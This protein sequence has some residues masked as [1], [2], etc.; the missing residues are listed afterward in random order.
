MW[1]LKYPTFTDLQ[2]YE[3]MMLNDLYERVVHCGNQTIKDA[4]IPR[5]HKKIL[6]TL[7][8]GKVWTAYTESEKLM[9]HIFTEY[10]RTELN[11]YFK[12]IHTKRSLRNATQDALIAKYQDMMGE[13]LDVLGYNEA[14]TNVKKA[15]DVTEMKGAKACTYCNRGYIFTISTGNRI[16]DKIARPELDH[17]Y[18]KSKYPLLSMNYFNLIPS[19]SVCNSSVKGSKDFDVKSHVHPY[20]QR[21]NNPNFEFKYNPM[22]PKGEQVTI[23]DSNASEK[24][25]NSIQAFKLKEVYNCHAD[26]EAKELYDL[27]VRHGV[28]YIRYLL[29]LLKD[30]FAEKTEQDIYRMVFGAEL[31]PQYFG[32]RPMSKFK[33]DLLKQMKL[34]K[35]GHYL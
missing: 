16:K 30:D 17:W 1:K 6:Q 15:Y 27:A 18:P 32:N 4:L 2:T 34:I 24:E 14:F 3:G 11:Q 22:A 20:L 8:T 5:D 13:L 35:D 19:C 29:E 33:Y 10:S 21:S 23:D 7:L 9:G 31:D 25:R 28:E 26:L 12:A